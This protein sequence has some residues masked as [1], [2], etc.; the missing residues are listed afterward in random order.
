[1]SYS[2]QISVPG[3]LSRF[4]ITDGVSGASGPVIDNEQEVIHLPETT[5]VS[6][7]VNL[8]ENDERYITSLLN[9]QDSSNSVRPIEKVNTKKI[10][11]GYNVQE[12]SAIESLLYCDAGAEFLQN[13]IEDVDGGK[14]I[15]AYAG[16]Y[17]VPEKLATDDIKSFCHAVNQ[18][19]Q[20]YADQKLYITRDHYNSFGLNPIQ[21]PSEF[22]LRSS[23]SSVT[24][25]TTPKAAEYFLTG[26]LPHWNINESDRIEVLQAAQTNKNIALAATV[27]SEDITIQDLDG[28]EQ[29][30]KSRYS[31]PV[32]SVDEGVVTLTDFKD[33][34]KEYR[35][36]LNAV[37]SNFDYLYAL[38]FD[39]DVAGDGDY[40][41]Q[42]TTSETVKNNIGTY[43]VISKKD[44]GQVIGEITYK[45][46]LFGED[47][48]LTRKDVQYFDA[49]AQYVE[50]TLNYNNNKPYEMI[51]DLCKPE[52]SVE[53]RDV[54]YYND[55]GSVIKHDQFEPDSEGN[56]VNIFTM[57]A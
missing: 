41:I 52:G 4:G 13:A 36:D 5:D 34:L 14:V 46:K 35:F 57:P 1:M 10:G 16:D 22:A 45:N 40:S 7:P 55:N 18:A 56:L 29:M 49:Y 51:V 26:K 33:N 21:Y 39:R 3:L 9:D 8:M 20:D 47:E 6:A 42:R 17:F 31:Y 37:A 24:G 30:F 44:D 38:D 50:T 2:E 43:T 54:Y 15:H 25:Y 53:F 48:V 27:G 11:T 28:N 12:Y 23:F 19:V 32:K